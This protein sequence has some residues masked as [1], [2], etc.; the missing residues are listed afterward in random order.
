MKDSLKIYQIVLLFLLFWSQ[1]AWFTWFVESNKIIEYFVYI[2]IFVVFFV[3]K[4]QYK[5]TIRLTNKSI[6]AIALFS[7]GLLLSMDTIKAIPLVLIKYL[8]FIILSCDDKNSENHLR[9][10]SMVLGWTVIIGLIPYLIWLLDTWRLPYTLLKFGEYEDF[11]NYYLF[12]VPS[13]SFTGFRY[14]SVFL[15]PGHLGTLCAFF[16]YINDYN[17]KK[18]YN[19]FFLIALI[20]SLSLAGYVLSILGYFFFLWTNNKH[21]IIPLLFTGMLF[22]AFTVVQQINDGDNEI[23]MMI[24]DR[25]QYDDEKGIS[26]ND[27]FDYAVDKLYEQSIQ[28]GDIWFGIGGEEFNRRDL[29]GSGYKMFILHH[30]IVAY[31]FIWL[32]YWF[33][34]FNHVDRKRAVLLCVMLYLSFLKTT[35][36]VTYF[37]L[38]TFYLYLNTHKID[39]RLIRNY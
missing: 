29:D 36:P 11:Y 38:V 1:H 39:R 4:S 22:V 26:G 12:I 6:I 23:N 32:F 19:V 14:Q 31:L 16:L 10:I 37:W 20:F 17:L 25:L 33:A 24:I 27:R 28:N 13:L 8:P 3:Y 18:I 21:F 7:L 9:I 35:E 34:A 30:G 2:L 15:E 5:I